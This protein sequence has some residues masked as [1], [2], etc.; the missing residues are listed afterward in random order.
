MEFWT[1]LGTMALMTNSLRHAG[2]IQSL[3]HQNL[4]QNSFLYCPY[5]VC[6]S[7]FHF[8]RT[9]ILELTVTKHLWTYLDLNVWNKFSFTNVLVELLH[10]LRQGF[11]TLFY[12]MEPF[13]SLVKT[14]DPSFSQ[15]CIEIHKINYTNTD[16]ISSI[17]IYIIVSTTTETNYAQIQFPKYKKKK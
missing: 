8:L 4:A 9:E 3:H 5:F 7:V 15:K 10:S 14:N 6:H 2:Q 12:A 16:Y 17:T 11:L 13:D 1:I